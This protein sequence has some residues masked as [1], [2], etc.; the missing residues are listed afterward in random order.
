MIT[1][2]CESISS[3]TTF[4]LNLREE[5]KNHHNQGWSDS[6]LREGLLCSN[7]S[8]HLSYSCVCPYEPALFFPRRGMLMETSW[9]PDCILKG[10]CTPTLPFS[11]LKHTVKTGLREASQQG[12]GLLLCQLELYAGAANGKP[13]RQGWLL[14]PCCVRPGGGH[15]LFSATSHVC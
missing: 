2:C 3:H 1:V 12:A 4:I 6:T 9:L 14:K 13:S 7:Q 11:H 10:L 8:H 5:I 15:E